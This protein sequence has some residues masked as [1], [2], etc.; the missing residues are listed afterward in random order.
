MDQQ[1]MLDGLT[2]TEICALEDKVNRGFDKANT[3][4]FDTGDDAMHG[5]ADEIG[6]VICEVADSMHVIYDR[7]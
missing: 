2:F 6:S 5:V 1:G 3:L 4:A 7:R